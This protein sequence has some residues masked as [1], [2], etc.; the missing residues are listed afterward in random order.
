LADT[1]HAGYWLDYTGGFAVGASATVYFKFDGSNITMGGTT[2]TAASFSTDVL[3][4]TGQRVVIDTA[5]GG[6]LRFYDSTN[7]N[8]VRIGESVYS[9]H[10]VVCK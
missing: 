8:V 4:S 10:A 6:Q 1:A 9:G 3:S 5:S 2:I 7:I